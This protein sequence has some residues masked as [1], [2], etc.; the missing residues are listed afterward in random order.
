M[1]ELRARDVARARVLIE[2]AQS[3]LVDVVVGEESDGG[4]DA[5]ALLD[6]VKACERAIA[7]CRSTE[8]TNNAGDGGGVN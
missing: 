1:N 4:K 7:R 2:D 6:A 8:A 3:L 5:A